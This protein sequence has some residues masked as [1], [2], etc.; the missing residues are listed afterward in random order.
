MPWTFK[1][2]LK[3]LENKTLRYPGHWE[4]MKAYRELGLFSRKSIEHNNQKIVPRDFYHQL[5]EEKI[6]HGRVEDVCLMRI[7][8][9][10][11]KDSKK[12]ELNLD[13]IELYDKKLGLTA[14]EKWTGWHISIMAIEIAYNRIDKGAIS[15][16]NA[17][18]GHI[19]L[20]EA[21]K[22]NYNIKIDIKEI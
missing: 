5:L 9:I 13:A 18:K 21:K 4:W 14:M 12:V 8:A 20:E 11:K 10:G 22:R 16:E 19:F 6:N 15:V 3:I 2:K 7:R 17:L 1:E